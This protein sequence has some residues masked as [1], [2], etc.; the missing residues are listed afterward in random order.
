MR[1]SI[2]RSALHAV[3][4]VVAVLNTATSNTPR[5]R[6]A[7]HC[8]PLGLNLCLQG[9]QV[10]SVGFYAGV[11]GAFVL[12]RKLFIFLMYVPEFGSMFLA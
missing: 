3:C 6:L 2:L 10:V 9:R 12:A 8:T 5:A 1:E 7:E 11:G 4:F